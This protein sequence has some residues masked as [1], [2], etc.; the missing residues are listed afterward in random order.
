M[1]GRVDYPVMLQ[2]SRGS[3]P[4]GAQVDGRKLSGYKEMSKRITPPKYLF[5][6]VREFSWKFFSN[7]VVYLPVHLPLSVRYEFF[8]G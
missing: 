3:G 1:A 4:G 2:A 8:S 6:W 5:A 7:R